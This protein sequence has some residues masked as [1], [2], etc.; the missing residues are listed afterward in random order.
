MR[1]VLATSLAALAGAAAIAGCGGGSSGSGKDALDEAL[2]YLPK[3]APLVVT[4]G[5]DPNGSQWKS[6][7][8]I[9]HKFSFGDQVAQ[10]LKQSIS[11]Q[12]LDFDKQVKPL[13]GNPAVIGAP[14]AQSILGSGHSYVIALKVKDKGKLSSVLKQSKF[15][16]AD[17]SSNGATLYAQN[18]GGSEIGQA[19]DVLIASD[20]KANVVQALVQRNKS[21]RLTEDQF[22]S[23]LSD[24]PKD[25]LV[26][27]YADLRTLLGDSPSTAE[28]R[29]VKWIAALRTLGLTGQA[30]DNAISFDF[31]LKTDPSGLTDADVPIATGDASPGVVGKPGELVF[32]LRGV[33][34]VI[35]FAQSVAQTIS[36]GSFADFAR[37]KAQIGARLGID[38]D[39]DVI[40]QF[41]G[42]T[43]IA[44]SLNG[45]YAI[46]AE[47]KD[48]A[49]FS[50][51][52]AKLARVAPSFASGIGL[53]GARLTK[54]GG[55]Y[56]LSGRGKSKDVYFGVVNNVFVISTDPARIA[57]LAAAT[58]KSVP[59]AKGAFVTSSDAGAILA[60]IISSFA[61]GGLGGQL[62]GSLASAPLGDLDGWAGASTSGLKGHLQL[63]IK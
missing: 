13:L 17:G 27:V 32:G 20:T 51:T 14:T 16:E 55:L 25:A 11:N 35:D 54:S 63:G 41:S 10:Q 40:D 60:Q 42:N 30:T 12:G 57:Q 3:S 61:G 58:P 23:A 34:Q 44:V 36:P 29:K 53:K 31:N 52:L 56:K 33:N 46:R 18:Q 6:L 5:T 62:G 49:A 15:L 24:L 47:L 9:L 37:A 21:D 48:P 1:K 59:G 43:S 28:A 8:A 22:N 50:K 2:G 26:R 19:G 39:K 45:G 7:S 4:I 38:V